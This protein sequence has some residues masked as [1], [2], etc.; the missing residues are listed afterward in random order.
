VAQAERE[1]V[2]AGGGKGG[3]EAGGHRLRRAA[4][5]DLPADQVDPD[6]GALAEPREL[7]QV[8]GGERGGL[9]A[10]GHRQGAAVD[11][12]RQGGR[13][14]RAGVA[15][16][17]GE[18]HRPQGLAAGAGHVDRVAVIEPGGGAGR[19]RAV[20]E[21]E[22]R[23]VAEAHL[24]GEVAG[25]GTC[26]ES[27]RAP[28]SR[29]GSAAVS[30]VPSVPTWPS[31]LMSARLKAVSARTP[32]PQSVVAPSAPTSAKASSWRNSSCVLPAIQPGWIS[33]GA[34][35]T[36]ELIAPP[37]AA[38]LV[39]T[40]RTPNRISRIVI[41][42]LPASAPRRGRAQLH[43]TRPAACAAGNGAKNSINLRSAYPPAAVR[44]NV[45]G[46]SVRRLDRL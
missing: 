21:A 27:G 18:R 41:N 45:L 19:V 20:L 28:G 23:R 14:H 32:L 13:G 11:V 39:S 34:P 31:F 30:S 16:V 36:P 38:P 24:V 10:A 15:E 12:E 2:A 22:A 8:V 43:P 37:A 44:K 5:R 26:W 33:F 3:P 1:V 4:D 29:T 46:D 42:A 35:A 25:L 40:A 9:A 17:D 6:L 7:E